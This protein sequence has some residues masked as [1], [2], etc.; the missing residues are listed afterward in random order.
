MTYKILTQVHYDDVDE[1]YS[2][3]LGPALDAK[4]RE[5]K[6]AIAALALLQ[7]PAVPAAAAAGKVG[8][9]RAMHENLA[10]QPRIAEYQSSI[11][12]LKK[13]IKR[14]GGIADDAGNVKRVRGL[15]VVAYDDTPELQAMTKIDIT[16]GLLCKASGGGRLDTRTMSNFFSGAGV[17]IFVL[18]AR[19]SLHVSN[20]IIH[21]RHHSSILAGIPIAAAGEISVND[22]TIT[23]ISNESGHY[24]PTLDH[25]LQVLHHLQKRGADPNG[26]TIRYSWGSGATD[27]ADYR[28]PRSLDQLLADN[29]L[30][31]DSYE[32]NNLLYAYKSLLTPH[33]LG[34]QGWEYRTATLAGQKPG[35]Y[36]TGTAEMV[37]HRDVRHFLK[38]RGA[39]FTQDTG[40]PQLLPTP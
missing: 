15:G 11:D 36:K 20:Q 19:G 14:L 2:R 10:R 40:R 13:Q 33:V 12:L 18:S 32:W 35:V 17:A 38:G 3:N 4:K 26:A 27:F 29:G 34:G 24:L 6:T 23:Y 8:Q 37:P 9:I 31:D 30:D 28:P 22:G 5:L 1:W 39:T 21:Q 25:F 16:A 7:A